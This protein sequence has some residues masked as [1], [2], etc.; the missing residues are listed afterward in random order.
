MKFFT[1]KNEQGDKPDK[2][3]FIVEGN[4]TIIKEIS[5][6]IRNRYNLIVL[7]FRYLIGVRNHQMAQEHV[8]MGRSYQEKYKK[9]YFA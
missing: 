8:G 5:I 4:V 2:V 7:T 1:D 9:S 3:Y 6:A